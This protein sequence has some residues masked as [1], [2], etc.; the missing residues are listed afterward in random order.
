MA[1]KTTDTNK[2]VEQ[3]K[4]KPA[5]FSGLFK[6]KQSAPAAPKPAAV[7]KPAAKAE[8]TPKI[9]VLTCYKCKQEVSGPEL[10]K[11]KAAMGQHLKKA[12]HLFYKT[13]TRVIV[14]S[15]TDGAA[16]APAAPQAA[17]QEAK[18]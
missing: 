11:A 15:A 9:H 1:T 18:S 10:A 16:V 5:P 8:S 4:P 7:A 14:P 12:G 6:K 3:Q 17:P 13:Q 2:P